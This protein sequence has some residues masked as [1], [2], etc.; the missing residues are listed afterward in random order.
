MRSEGKMAP[1]DIRVAL[2][3]AAAG[4]VRHAMADALDG[5]VAD[6]VLADAQLVLSELVTNSVHHA[7]VSGDATLRV[8]ASLRDGVLRLE[9]DDEGTVGRVATREPSVAG[10]GFGLQLVEAL[11]RTWGV[12]RRGRTRVWAELAG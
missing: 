3:P 10:G 8:A 1:V 4:S 5:H 6:H 12:E 11:S 9:V 7:R 2:S